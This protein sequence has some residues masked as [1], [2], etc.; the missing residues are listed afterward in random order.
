MSQRDQRPTDAD[1]SG[2][3]AELFPSDYPSWRYCIEVKCGLPLT[4]EYL[5][6]RLTVLTDPGQEETQRFIQTYGKAYW[7]QVLAW[8]QQAA[9]DLA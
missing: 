6:E 1:R 2:Y 8:F 9:A 5:A 3:D 4:P 7:E